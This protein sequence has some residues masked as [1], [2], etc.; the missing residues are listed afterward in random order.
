MLRSGY[1]RLHLHKPFP[2]AQLSLGT[3]QSSSLMALWNKLYYRDR[4]GVLR[5]SGL[6]YH[7]FV[8]LFLLRV[9]GN[10]KIE[11][12]FFFFFRVGAF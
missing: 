7:V 5:S 6:I 2:V 10:G 4:V 8:K 3:V 12:K 9:A 11:P 1:R